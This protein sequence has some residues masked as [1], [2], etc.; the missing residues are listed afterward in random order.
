MSQ[1]FKLAL[2]LVFFT[3][4]IILLI[5]HT[6]G[7]LYPGLPLMTIIGVIVVL[8]I[9]AFTNIGQIRTVLCLCLL[10]V[11]SRLWT[12]IFPAS[13]IRFDPDSYAVKSQ[14]IVNTGSL[15]ATISG[16]YQ[17]AAMFPLTGSIATLI[18]G[19]P[20]DKSY[21]IYPIVVGLALPLFAA[22][23]ARRISKSK[24]VGP[25]AA[26]IV[27]AGA[28]STIFAAAP[29]PITLAAIY[30]AATIIT[31]TVA[32][33][34]F[35][36]QKALVY[37][38]FAAAAG[39]THKISLFLLTGILVTYTIYTGV[40]TVFGM[41]IKNKKMGVISLITISL[42]I[43]QWFYLTDFI[44][45]AIYQISAVVLTE[46]RNVGTT[47]PSAA[48][49]ATRPLI[50]SLQNNAFYLL[51]L[52][53]GGFAG[54]YVFRDF[55]QWR[56]R[57][58]QS[59]ALITVVVTL[60]SAVMG[61]GP[62]FQRIYIYASVFVAALISVAIARIVS[63]EIV[64]G[65][66]RWK[67]RIAIAVLIVLVIVN[68]L[69]VIATPDYPGTSRQYLTEQEVTGKTWTNNYV[70]V[71]VYR[72]LYYGDEV[73]DFKRAA[74]GPTWHQEQVPNPWDPGLLN[75]ELYNGTLPS[76]DYQV[77]SLR[78]DVTYYRLRGG[79]YR[80]QWNPIAKMDTKSNRIYANGGVVTYVE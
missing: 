8:I 24:I 30:V 74:E 54:I 63:W 10:A 36:L 57:L 39:L 27:T 48:I 61:S 32:P 69:S 47:N 18:F 52:L 3:V 20:V 45:G 22:V 71:I 67:H 55:Y 37:L 70:S 35:R 43:V 77:V 56:V 19:I 6:T 21:S 59:A 75:E 79:D 49:R 50:I 62:G 25:I 44:L 15:E 9:Y 13:M 38:L 34:Q 16:F 76:K 46:V 41:E 72:D 4:A 28:A 64:R 23:L 51:S 29:I 78:T 5:T 60:P 12:F 58:L 14:V 42:L 1:G 53:F 7:S 68:P 26:A 11:A 31:L 40:V 73:V 66:L 80:L 2:S 65:D 33:T 17:S